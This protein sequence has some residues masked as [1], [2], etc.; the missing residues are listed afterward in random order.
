MSFCGEITPLEVALPLGAHSDHE[1]AQGG[2]RKEGRSEGVAPVD[3]D[4]I[5]ITW[6]A[7]RVGKQNTV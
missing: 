5:T 4:A 3:L 1:L 2:R 7:W 6:Q